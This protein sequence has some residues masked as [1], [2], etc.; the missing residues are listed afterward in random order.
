[1]SPEQ[2]KDLKEDLIV[3]DMGLAFALCHY[4]FPETRNAIKDLQR[5]MIEINRKFAELDPNK[6]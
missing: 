2:F 1:M 5:Q 4:G 3:L 6:S